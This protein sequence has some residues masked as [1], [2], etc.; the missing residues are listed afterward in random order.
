MQESMSELSLVLTQKF[1]EADAQAIRAALNRHLRVSEP[2]WLYRRSIDP[3]QVVQ[4]LGAALAWQ[5]LVKPATAFTKS[6]FST[7]GKRAADAAWDGAVE[8]TKDKDLTP[9]ADVATALVAAADSVGGE[10]IISV[11]LN[12]PDDHFG[13]V[14]STE[15]RDPLEVARTLAAFV[16]RAETISDAV[17]AEIE[18]GYEPIGPFFMEL[19]QDGSVT[20]RWHAARD[21]KT[22]ERRIP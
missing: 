20:I 7:L 8:W 4:L 17:Q 19:E 22:Y 2:Q 11:G 13:T 3:P 5:I 14:I 16:V 18:R 15:S 1:T 12:I 9:L 21:S 6:F 10:V